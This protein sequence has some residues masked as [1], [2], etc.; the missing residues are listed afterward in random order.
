MSATVPLITEPSDQ[1]AEIE[2][3]KKELQIAT[4]RA[5]RYWNLLYRC[6][7]CERRPADTEHHLVPKSLGGGVGDPD[8]FGR[9]KVMLC[10]P[11]HSALHYLVK[12]KDLGKSYRTIELILDDIPLRKSIQSTAKALFLDE[13]F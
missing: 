12:E 13:N 8:M 4:E 1:D 6:P 5:S 10:R 7:I 11:C 3:L 2:R 9:R